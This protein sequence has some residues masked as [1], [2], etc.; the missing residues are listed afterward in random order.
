MMRMTRSFQGI[1][2]VPRVFI[3]AMYKST[4]EVKDVVER[5]AALTLQRGFR[6]LKSSPHIYDYNV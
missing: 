3:D 2:T 4:V 6:I 1:G 5:W